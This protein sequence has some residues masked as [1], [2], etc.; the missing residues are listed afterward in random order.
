[1]ADA[2]IIGHDDRV[3]LLDGEVVDMPPIGPEH[4]HS[5]DRLNNLFHE[6]F[7]GVAWIRIQNPVRLNDRSEPVPDV[8]V[9]RL[10]GGA[11]TP[12]K[13]VH[14][15]PKDILLIVEVAD[16]SL[17]SDL[18]TKARLYARHNVSQ[19]WVLDL[20]GGRLFVHRDPTARGYETRLEL[21]RG[22]SVTATEFPIVTFTVDEI[23]G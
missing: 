2:E 16:S 21:K 5:I 9:A 15:A 18:T 3:E 7:R 11:D 8:T 4:A 13:S 20:R 22:D 1:M 12:Y 10:W 23:L 19:F 14:P 17:A 6:R